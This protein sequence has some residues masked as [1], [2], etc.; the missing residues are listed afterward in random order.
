MP[1]T[2]ILQHNSA[3]SDA[4]LRAITPSHHPSL[5]R[6]GNC[7]LFTELKISM[8]VFPQELGCCLQCLVP[9][10][11]YPHWRSLQGH[12]WAFNPG[13][14]RASLAS[15]YS[16]HCSASFQELGLLHNLSPTY[17]HCSVQLVI[18]LEGRGILPGGQCQHSS[19]NHFTRM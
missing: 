19:R 18:K 6:K 10:Q 9:L 11:L 12:K 8:Q 17:T 15:I 3:C 14:H 16:L 2:A 4:S 13:F 5:F 7:S 1:G